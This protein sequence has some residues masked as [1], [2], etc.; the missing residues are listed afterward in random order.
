MERRLLAEKIDGISRLTGEFVLRS[1]G[2]STKYFDKYQFESFP[3][4]LHEIAV[5]ASSLIPDETDILAGL[6]MGGI[7]IATVLSQV[8]GLPT[9]FVRKQAKEY[10]TRRLAEGMDIKDKNILVIEDVITT[11]GQVA[12]STL[13]LR[14]LG[15]NIESAMCVIDRREG[16]QGILET[17]DL[18]VISLFTS[19]ELSS[20]RF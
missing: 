8:T 15:A 19:E 10:R 4:V 17:I 18:K 20:N 9:V 3:E 2:V 6:I 7:P 12:T 14:E 13:A 5:Q 11:G 16:Y 1:V